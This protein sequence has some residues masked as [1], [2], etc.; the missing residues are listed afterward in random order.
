[1]RSYVESKYNIARRHI[2]KM[3]SEV[4]ELSN[5][6]TILRARVAGVTA[7]SEANRTYLQSLIGTIVT[8]GTTAGPVSGRILTLGEDYVQLVEAT[9]DLV[10]VPLANINYVSQ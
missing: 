7:P 4:N 2:N 8:V 1:M 6:I 5:Q 9:G 10:L 3:V